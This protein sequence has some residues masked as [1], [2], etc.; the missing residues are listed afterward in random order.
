MKKSA[1]VMWINPRIV[2]TFTR[3]RWS[4]TTFSSNLAGGE[5]QIH[6]IHLR[7]LLIILAT[8][9]LFLSMQVKLQLICSPPQP[10]SLQHALPVQSCE[11]K[12][13]PFMTGSQLCRA[14]VGRYFSTNIQYI[15]PTIHWTLSEKSLTESIE[16]LNTERPTLLFFLGPTKPLQSYG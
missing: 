8:L 10:V 9:L 16:E 1:H 11:A 4:S 13:L 3:P 6:L 12:C 5:D 15:Q 2:F 14:S 7:V